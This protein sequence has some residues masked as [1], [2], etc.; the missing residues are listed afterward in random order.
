MKAAV[1]VRY[2]K[3][4][5]V[6]ACVVF[7]TWQDGEPARLVRTEVPAA[8]RYRAGAFFEREL[9]CLLS[10]LREADHRFEA[11]VI[12]GYVHLRPE[13]GKGLGASLC[14]TLAYSTE[15]IGVAKKPLAVADRFVEVRRGRS[16]KP[17]FVSAIGC[18]V[19]RAAEHV[20]RMHGAYRIP[21]LLRLADR[22]ARGI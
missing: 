11:I 8:A 22:H 10:V 17:L 14:D 4:R 16:T 20:S 12:D 19:E 18:P 3:D 7:D 6:A 21:T 9:P 5:A 2:E 15:I 13:V 1:D